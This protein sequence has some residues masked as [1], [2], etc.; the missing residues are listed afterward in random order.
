M[1]ERGT[2]L[3]LNNP[4]FLDPSEN[5]QPSSSKEKWSGLHKS[6]YSDKRP[7]LLFLAKIDELLVIPF[8]GFT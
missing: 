8:G 1:S 7:L 4:S 2:Q 6:Y 5:M 3:P